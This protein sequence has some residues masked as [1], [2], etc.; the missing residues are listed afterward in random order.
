MENVENFTRHVDR[1]C[2][3]HEAPLGVGRVA[4]RVNC[5]LLTTAYEPG[6]QMNDIIQ[7]I[8]LVD[9]V[10]T[11]GDSKGYSMYLSRGSLTI[12]LVHTTGYDHPP[13]AEFMFYTTYEWC[14]SITSCD[15]PP[16]NSINKGQPGCIAHVVK[17][18]LYSFVANRR[19]PNVYTCNIYIG[20]R[21]L[22]EGGVTRKHPI[23]KG[24]Q[25][26]TCTQKKM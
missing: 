1:S 26:T 23:N 2:T 5:I 24:Q 17:Y 22:G 20:C 9:G 7:P 25:E 15:R 19:Q 18:V 11:S 16:L 4:R 13:C 14:N 12:Y 21:R 10:P 6:V 3:K 8:C